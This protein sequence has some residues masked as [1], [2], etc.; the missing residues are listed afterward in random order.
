MSELMW[1]DPASLQFPPTSLAL[2]DPNGL[3]A[4]GGDLCAARLLEA[5]RHGIFPWFDESQPIL[6]WTPDPRMI[7]TPETLH[8]GRSLKKLARKRPFY[9]TTD[10]AFADV[11]R[12]CA[13]PREQQEGTWITSD[14]EDAYT[15]LHE[16]GYAHSVEA[17]QDGVL[18][19]GLYGIALGRVF[20]GESMFSRVS[21]ASKIAFANMAT[22]LFGW[23]FIA[24]D[25]QI[26]SDYLLSF[27]AKDVSR[28]TFE[29]LLRLSE[30][31]EP[32]KYE[33]ESWESAWTV[34]REGKIF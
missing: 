12:G 3:L 17:W 33:Q 5:Y 28:T 27:G 7:L 14:M 4:V 20:F 15:Q 16:L 2:E 29:N 30:E 8:L 6:W 34:P 24:I 22:E 10:Q 9:I 11:M 23:G 26:A 32:L 18:V 25:C 31:S 13:A 1:L 21:G 19:G